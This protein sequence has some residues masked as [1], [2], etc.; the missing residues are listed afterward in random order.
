MLRWFVLLPLLTLAGVLQYR[1][2]RLHGARFPYE[3]LEQYLRDRFD[4][5]LAPTAGLPPVPSF[6]TNGDTF[7]DLFDR[8]TRVT[9]VPV[10]VH[11]DAFKDQGVGPT[12]HSA[13]REFKNL[14]PLDLLSELLIQMNPSEWRGGA[15]RADLHWRYRRGA[16]I[17]SSEADLDADVVWRRYST[18]NFSIPACGAGYFISS[19]SSVLTIVSLITQFRNHL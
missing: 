15:D 18:F 3:P 4:S 2:S 19:F 1:T 14:R 17:V 7:E 9:G 10:T 12:D 6:S 11:W 8:F 5:D 16:F 13:R